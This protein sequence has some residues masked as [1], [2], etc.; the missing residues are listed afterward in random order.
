M[1]HPHQVAGHGNLLR[2][3]QEQ[4]ATYPHPWLVVKQCNC[5]EVQ[6]Y[7]EM[8]TSHRSLIPYFPR[9]Y[10]IGQNHLILEDLTAPFTN[11]SILDIKVGYCLYTEPLDER[12][13]CR[14]ELL[15]K[16]TTAGLVG[17]RLTG[18]KLYSSEKNTYTIYDKTYGKHLDVAS[19]IVCFKKYFDK[20]ILKPLILRLREMGEV[21][22]KDVGLYSASLLFIHGKK[23]EDI[24]F[25]VRVIDM[26]HSYFSKEEANI[27]FIYGLQ[28]LEMILT[29]LRD[30]TLMS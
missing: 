17:L 10:E 3:T 30:E 11:P 1:L 22:C 19:L 28:C 26:A 23:K 21:F 29:A 27:S 9:C 15:E 5:T 13:R 24:S 12:K 6:F 14:M 16:T 2:L 8:Y 4:T 18:M 7:E 20:R 25:D